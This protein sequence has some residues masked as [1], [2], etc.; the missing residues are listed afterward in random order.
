MGKDRFGSYFVPV[1]SKTLD[2]LE[3]FQSPQEELSLEEVIRRT[4]MAHGTA[5]RILFTL[6]H[7]GYLAQSS[8]PKKYRLMPSPHRRKIGYCSLGEQTFANQ[9]AASLENAA[10]SAGFGLVM[11]NNEWDTHTAIRN[12]QTLVTER[13]DIA[14]NFQGHASVAPVVA[15]IL[16]RAKIPTIA[17]EIPQPGAIYYGVDNYRAGWDAGQV[18]AR[19]VVSLWNGR[20]D[21]IVLLDMPSAGDV[22]QSRL[23][24][25]LRSFEQAL[26]PIVNSKVVRVDG[27]STREPSKL[28]TANILRTHPRA[29][30]ILLAAANDISALGGLDALRAAGRDSGSA[31]LGFGRMQEAMPEIVNPESPYFLTVNFWPERYGPGLIDLVIRLLAGEQVAPFHYIEH[32]MI[33]RFNIRRHL[34][35]V[36]PQRKMESPAVTIAITDRTDE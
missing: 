10:R 21:L 23:T 7:R 30:H 17:V 22:A 5:Y 19:H 15:D 16:A 28:V 26:G 6:V 13:V 20:V 1:V 31:I 32:Q 34:P 14:I 25:V 8:Q 3:A 24:G 18:L 4:G 12:A 36:L 9:V 2:I 33:D 27:K 35:T 11:L 29:E